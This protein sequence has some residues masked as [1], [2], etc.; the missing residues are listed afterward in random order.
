MTD[1][2]EFQKCLKN[3]LNW[4]G[5]MW[6]GMNIC[7]CLYVHFETI[8]CFTRNEQMGSLETFQG[9]ANGAKHTHNVT[10]HVGTHSNDSGE[11]M[12]KPQDVQKCRKN[13]KN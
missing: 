8:L 3:S 10:S 6:L 4:K 1:T 9:N 7:G 13:N 2:R 5:V 11:N 12:T